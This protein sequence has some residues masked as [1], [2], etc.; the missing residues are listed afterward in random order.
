MA[1]K[2]EDH[3]GPRKRNICYTISFFLSFF[4]FF[5]FYFLRSCCDSAPHGQ[6]SFFCVARV[7]LTQ[8]L[9]VPVRQPVSDAVK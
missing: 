3:L 9:K 7:S 8:T 1:Q 6:Q 2:Y 5:S 4:L